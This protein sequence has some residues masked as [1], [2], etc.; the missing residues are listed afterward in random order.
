MFKKS[1]LICALAVAAPFAA[2]AADGV[3]TFTGAVL[4]STCSVQATNGV[5]GNQ[6]VTLPT[7]T[8][9]QLSGTTSTA[10]KTAG[11]TSFSI[12]VAGS[13]CTSL[14]V[15][16]T[17]GTQSATGFKTFFETT[18]NVDSSGRLKNLASNGAT[19]VVLELLEKG[20]TTPLD[21]SKSTAATQGV[22]KVDFVATTNPT[23]TQSAQ[24]NF[25]ARYYAN[26]ASVSAGPVS[27][28]IAYTIV[29]E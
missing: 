18:S 16:A 19:G 9:D 14:Q 20:A 21:L 4:S 26:T 28:N 23:G 27:S 7:V 17:S 12:T 24:A 1:A 3:L 13:G 11:E 8:T 22:T 2:Q 6:T 15:P 29:Y 25:V 10:A 5:G